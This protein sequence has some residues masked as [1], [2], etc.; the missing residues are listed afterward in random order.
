V[1]DNYLDDLIC[2]RLN[3]VNEAY[4]EAVLMNR[5]KHW[6]TCAKR[7]FYP[8]CY[9]VI[10][11][12]QKYGFRADKHSGVKSLFSRYFVKIGKVNKELGKFAV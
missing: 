7:L 11:F 3:W 10:T 4:K 1:K 9:A 12:L 6:N 5:E 2:L 8:C